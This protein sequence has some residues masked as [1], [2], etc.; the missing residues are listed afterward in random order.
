M[1]SASA[2]SRRP[3][4]SIST[5]S[6]A[7]G[8]PSRP[9]IASWIVRDS[10]PA[11]P[12]S[13]AG[14]DARAERGGLVER[15]ADPAQG[16]RGHHV[17]H[18][19]QALR[20]RDR[21]RRVLRRVGRGE[22]VP[23]DGAQCGHRRRDRGGLL[24][25]RELAH[26]RAERREIAALQA[27]EVRVAPDGPQHGGAQHRRVA[28]DRRRR[29]RRRTRQRPP[30]DEREQPALGRHLAV[31]ERSGRHVGD[32]TR[33]PGAEGSSGHEPRW[34]PGSEDGPGRTSTARSWPRAPADDRRCPRQGARR[35][36]PAHGGGRPDRRRARP[37]A[38]RGRRPPPAT[39]PPSPTARWTATRSPPG[40]AGRRLRVTGESRAGRAGRR[41]RRRR[42]GVPDLHRRGAARRR[43]RGA[44]GRARDRRGRRGR[45]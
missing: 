37:R 25:G 18:Q 34:I 7:K 9:A 28:G 40:P 24:G 31:R 1:P 13:G 17:A 14:D 20:E 26:A 42:R 15:R 32:R 16:G 38:G 6:R 19:A 10:V 44:P 39:C 29:Q 5:A 43:R 27:P 3:A 35:G 22:R 8:R 41:R 30:R 33:P 45:S 2:P 4:S 11:T 21:V 12:A 36:P 23:Q